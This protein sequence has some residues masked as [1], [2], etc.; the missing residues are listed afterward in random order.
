MQWKPQMEIFVL[1]VATTMFSVNFLNQIFVMEQIL[2]FFSYKHMTAVSK[3]SY[4]PVSEIWDIIL[5]HPTCP[6]NKSSVLSLDVI[7]IEDQAWP[8]QIHSRCHGNHA[9]P[10]WC[11][12]WQRWRA[13]RPTGQL[14]PRGRSPCERVTCIMWLQIKHET[15]INSKDWCCECVCVFVCV[16]S[17]GC[18]K[19]GWDPEMLVQD[20][21]LENLMD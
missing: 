11:W 3:Q 16:C 7:N 10:E 20:H 19:L 18:L 17:S 12:S 9:G 1:C 4:Q 14:F 5:S 21:L 6:F 13:A 8:L 2:Q 15:H